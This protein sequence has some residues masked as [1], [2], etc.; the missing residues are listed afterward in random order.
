MSTVTIRNRYR[1]ALSVTA[2]AA[3]GVS[4]VYTAA[5]ALAAN[6]ISVAGA[7]PA[8][9]GVEYACEASAGVSSIQVMV[10]DPNADRPAAS[11]AQMTFD[12]DGSQHTATIPLT[13]AAGESPLAAGAA[14]QVRAALVNQEQTVVSGTAKLLTLG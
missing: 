4:L 13:P 3:L 11:G 9:V 1:S 2:F 5:P 8:S 10:G 14:V 6:S 12:C 7:A